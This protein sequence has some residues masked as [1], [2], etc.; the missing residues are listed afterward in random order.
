MVRVRR[1]S[2]ALFL[3][4]VQE[5]LAPVIAGRE[6]LERRLQVLLEGAAV[7]GIPLIWTEQYVKGLGVTIPSVAER[8]APRANPIEKLSFSCC[9]APGVDD[10]LRRI[11]PET[12]IVSGIETH[13]CVLQTCLDLLDGGYLPVLVADCTGSRHPED[14][15]IALRRLEQA[16]VVLTTLESLLFELLEQAGSDEFKA[17]SR[18]VKPL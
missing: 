10:S 5:R 6:G 11:A 18:L 17:I 12:V 3:I 8:A 7:L 14:R 1:D 2:T 4:D 13:V 15:E 9:P 16:G